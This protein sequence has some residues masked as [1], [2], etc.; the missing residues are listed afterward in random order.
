MREWPS[1][2]TTWYYTVP[3]F[4]ESVINNIFDVNYFA[5]YAYDLVFRSL[6]TLSCLVAQSSCVHHVNTS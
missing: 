5:I 3:T 2:P 4:F 6:L 1:L